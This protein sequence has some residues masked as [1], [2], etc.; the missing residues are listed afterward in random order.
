MQLPTLSAT[1]CCIDRSERLWTPHSV[2]SVLGVKRPALEADD[3]YLVKPKDRPR[4]GYEG[5]EGEFRHCSTLSLTSALDGGWITSRPGRFTPGK[6]TR[7][8]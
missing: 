8:S 1:D 3:F 4:T 7:Y 2:R 5:P 6:E